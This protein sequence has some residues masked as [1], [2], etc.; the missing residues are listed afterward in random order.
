MLAGYDPAPFFCELTTPRAGD[1]GSLA[2][3][4]RR[5]AAL[6]LDELRR[7]SSA[8]ERDLFNLGITFTVYSEATAI[9]RILPFDPVPR[10]LTA[11]EWRRLEAGVVQRV[12]ALNLFLHDVY[13]AQS[14]LRDGVVPA[15]LVLGNANYRPE[16]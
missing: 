1:A 3:I 13:N 6:P 4:V 9:D 16:M 15:D 12:R 10:V 14:I 11:G 8:A 7:R 2:T 5:L